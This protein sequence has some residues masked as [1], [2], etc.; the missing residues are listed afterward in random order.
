[1]NSKQHELKTARC[2]L[3]LPIIEDSIRIFDAISFPAYP[4]QLVMSQL[5]SIREAEAWVEQILS[6][7][8]NGTLYAWSFYLK[9]TP[10]LLG[11]IRLTKYK[12]TE[13]WSLA[14]WCHPDSWGKGFVF[15]AA[16]YALDYA[17]GHLS[18]NLI[19]A[20]AGLWNKPSIRIL[21]KLGMRFIRENNN[22]YAVDNEIIPTREYE[23]D[24]E[25]WKNSR[26]GLLRLKRKLT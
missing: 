12:D 11:Q 16:T 19:F 17:F 5:K 1:M 14:F 7:F 6:G 10:S 21:E 15:E 2:D 3:R 23:I 20:G 9:D 18:I 25:T 8:K 22:G 13:K 4:K 26:G 24:A